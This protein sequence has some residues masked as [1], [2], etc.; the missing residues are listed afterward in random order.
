VGFCLREIETSYFVLVW[1]RFAKHNL[2]INVIFDAR[3]PVRI[4]SS[5][6]SLKNLETLNRF[7]YHEHN[8]R[9]RQTDI[10]HDA[11]HRSVIAT[12]DKST[13]TEQPFN[14]FSV[15]VLKVNDAWRIFASNLQNSSHSQ[16]EPLYSIKPAFHGTNIDT[17]TDILAMI[18]AR[19]SAR[20]SVIN[21]CIILSC[22]DLHT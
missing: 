9:M 14:G 11:R 4:P 21:E 1:V 15:F 5:L 22:S 20:M 17:D 6:I 18:R 2:L 16:V 10:Q 8:T 12:C 7:I 19:M 13:K 3:Q